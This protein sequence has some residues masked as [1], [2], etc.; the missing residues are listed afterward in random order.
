MHTNSRE[1]R[2]KKIICMKKN[3]SDDDG[4][5]TSKIRAKSLRFY[6]LRQTAS[7]NNVRL[8]MYYI[9]N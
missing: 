4:T 6:E 1:D 5:R 8:S 7:D 9:F 2:F 3:I